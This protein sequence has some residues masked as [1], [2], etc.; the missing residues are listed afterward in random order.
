MS[1]NN[2]IRP[3]AVPFEHHVRRSV[4]R[5]DSAPAPSR[6]AIDRERT[7]TVVDVQLRE[8]AKHASLHPRHAQDRQDDAV[9]Q[10]TQDRI[11]R[12][13][14]AR[15]AVRLSQH[16]PRVWKTLLPIRIEQRVGR[17]V[18]NPRDLPCQIDSVLHPS[19]DP[20][21]AGRTVDMGRVSRDEHSVDAHPIHHPTVD[22]EVRKPQ[23]VS[24][25]RR[26]DAWCPLRHEATNVIERH[27]LLLAVICHFDEKPPGVRRRKRQGRQTT[28]PVQ[29]DMVL[30]VRQRATQPNVGH[31][32]RERVQFCRGTQSRLACGRRC[33]HP[34]S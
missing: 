1:S 13:E 20:L 32:K 33:A 29:P 25:D 30:F 34:H 4:T 27:R 16:F 9:A 3:P 12:E 18:L 6:S 17:A 21:S 22:P 14:Q 24:S 31:E 15:G 2:V 5:T 10:R 28:G 23:R 19:R 11:R 7:P 26:V 8:L